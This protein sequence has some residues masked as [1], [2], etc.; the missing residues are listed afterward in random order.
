MNE[1][2]SIISTVGFP[3]VAVIG[4]GYFYYQMWMH[5]TSENAKREES[6][7]SLIR[8]LSTNLANLGRIVDENTKVLAILKEKVDGIEEKIDRE[9]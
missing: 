2:V 8:E 7:M 4:M 6:L 9:G 1:I 5:Q 3:I